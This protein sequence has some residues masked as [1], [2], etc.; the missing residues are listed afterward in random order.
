M[1]YHNLFMWMEMNLNKGC[2]GY[3]PTMKSLVKMYLSNKQTPTLKTYLFDKVEASIIVNLTPNQRKN[4]INRLVKRYK[5][6]IK[7]KKLQS[8]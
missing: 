5:V 7:D 3:F 1:P 6:A 2:L 8:R 4:D